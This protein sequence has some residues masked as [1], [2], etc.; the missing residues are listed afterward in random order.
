MN[1]KID[2]SFCNKCSQNMC[3]MCGN[4]WNGV[5]SG[6]MDRNLDDFILEE[7]IDESFKDE[8]GGVHDCGTGWNPQGVF[9]GECS[10]ET[11]KGC[12]NEFTGE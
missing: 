7:Y 11:C 8:V 9:C 2:S 5:P 12:V 6:Y 10:R 4:Q 1:N 3:M